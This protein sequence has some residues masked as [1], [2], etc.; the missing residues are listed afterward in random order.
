MLLSLAIRDFVIVDTLELDFTAGFTV[1]TGETGAGK[2]IIID[3]LS[4]LLGGRGDGSLVRAGCERAELSARFDLARLPVLA[5]WLAE[6]ALADEGGELLVRRMLD[7]SGRSRC[8]LNGR[9]AT[10]AQLKTAGEWLVDIH[11]QHAHQ[12]LVKPDTQRELLDAY[13]QSGELVASVAER[14]RVWQDARQARLDAEQHAA[15]YALERERLTWQ[16]NEVNELNPQ[17][18]EWDTLGQQ[19]QRLANAAELQDEARHALNALSDDEG[20]LISAVAQLQGRLTRFAGVDTRLAPVAALLDSVDAELREALYA[21]RD[22]V[23]DIEQNPEELAQVEKR[24]D[25]LHACARKFRLRPEDLP[26]RLA[27]WRQQLA[28]LDNVADLDGLLASEAEALSALR[29]AAEVLSVRR[30][31]AASEL[32]ERISAEMHTLAMAGSR[33]DIVLTPL[34]TPGA[35]G[36]ESVEYQVAANAGSPLRPLAKVASGGELSRISLALQVVTSAVAAVPTLIFDEV[37]VGIGG[38][39]AEVVGKLLQRLGEQYQVL[40]ITHLPQV[41]AR[42]DVQ[43]QVSKSGEGEAGAVIS[44]IRP[45]SSKERVEEIARML[46]GEQITAT[47]RRHAREMLAG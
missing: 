13:A 41:A 27:D 2:S 35:H 20:N 17:P 5:D 26:Q 12:S 7:A 14:H 43:W 6:Q 32:A 22:Y 30:R 9:A 36:A 45:L 1:L 34:A 24:I 29:E 40:C 3:A 42:G 11:G 25:A 28:E 19:H 44:R 10:L 31:R 8:F 15:A 16:I 18:G 37:D 38:R 21:L 39:V 46:G 47:T 4:L 23:E 33:F